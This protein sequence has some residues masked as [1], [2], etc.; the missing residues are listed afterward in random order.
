MTSNEHVLKFK[1]NRINEKCQLSS[2]CV[3][4]NCFNGKCLCE[5]KSSEWLKYWKFSF[6]FQ[7]INF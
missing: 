1:A 6:V 4:N 5:G 3:T 7:K 2:D